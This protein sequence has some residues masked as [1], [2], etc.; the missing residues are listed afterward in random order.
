MESQYNTLC[1]I[2]LLDQTPVVQQDFY[3]QPAES[4]ENSGWAHMRTG[5]QMGEALLLSPSLDGQMSTECVNFALRF[6]P[7]KKKQYF[8]YEL[9]KQ[10]IIP[11]YPRSTMDQLYFYTYNPKGNA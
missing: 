8:R 3:A 6:F 9:E 11:K 7:E 4:V 2:L 5:N 10:I 1:H